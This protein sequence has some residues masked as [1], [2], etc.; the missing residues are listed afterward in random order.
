MAGSLEVVFLDL[1]G[2][3]VDIETDE[4][5][6]RTRRAFEHWMADV[7]GETAAARERDHALF[8]DVRRAK[9]PGPFGEPDLGPVIA[10]HLGA[11]IGRA[12]NPAEV[13]AAAIAFRAASRLRLAL[14]PGTVEALRRLAGRF[15]L[16]IVSN[17]QRLFTR[18]ELE[19]LGIGMFFDPVVLS[20]EVG[21]RKPGAEIFR[22]ALAAARARPSTTL[23]VGD[24]PTAD[25]VGAAA[26]GMRTCL[27]GRAVATGDVVPRPDL[28]VPSVAALPGLL[29]D[30]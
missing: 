25:V 1:Y 20:S 5:S 12:P 8:E 13:A 27:V 16:A 15:R 17:A 11:A 28:Q 6:P 4:G 14:L 7:H 3:L 23:H 18:P 21:V 9:A 24:D 29:L 30:S 26:L 10:A 2:T 19:Q 22:R